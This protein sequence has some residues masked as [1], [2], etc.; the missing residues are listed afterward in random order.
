MSKLTKE[1]LKD[2]KKSVEKV[3]SIQIQIGGVEIQKHELLHSVDIASKE[4]MTVQKALQE[5]YG[6]V[7]VDIETG[8]IKQNESSKED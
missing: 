6:D 8:K 3:N 4:L 2:L 5:K 7:S 1:E